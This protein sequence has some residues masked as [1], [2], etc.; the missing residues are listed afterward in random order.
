MDRQTD[1]EIDRYEDDKIKIM[2]EDEIDIIKNII[3]LLF[4]QTTQ[5]YQDL[6]RH[7]L[8]CSVKISKIVSRTAQGAVKCW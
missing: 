2:I 6:S 8:M 4:E 3:N 1:N 7:L 5:I